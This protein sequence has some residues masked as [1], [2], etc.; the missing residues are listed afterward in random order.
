ML[1]FG[2]RSPRRCDGVSRRDFLKI[3]T[4]GWGGLTLADAIRARALAAASGPGSASDRSVILIWLDGGPPQHETYDPKPN[5]PSEYRGPLRPIATAIPGVQFS[6]L[7]PR[8]AALLELEDRLGKARTP[9]EARQMAIDL[10]QRELAVPDVRCEEIAERAASP[11][12]AHAGHALEVPVMRSSKTLAGSTP[13]SMRARRWASMP[14][15]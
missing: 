4:L 15:S 12:Q 3:G 2:R 5:A 10:L 8:Q 11:A 9:D 7:L 6:E 1:E 13:A 14:P